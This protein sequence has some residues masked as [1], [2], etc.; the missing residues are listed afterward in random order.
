MLGPEH[1]M[2]SEM[3]TI[4]GLMDLTFFWAWID[5]IVIKRCR[6]K[7]ISDSYDC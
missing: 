7:V 5:N 2:V 4:P 6:R 1:T 3:D